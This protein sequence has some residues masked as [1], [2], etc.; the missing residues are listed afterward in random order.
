[1][2]RR[3]KTFRHAP[4]FS[5]QQPELR[6]ILAASHFALGLAHAGQEQWDEALSEYQ[7]AL[8]RFQALGQPWDIAN[9]QYEMGLVYSARQGAGDSDEAR[10]SFEQALV[11]FQ[12]LQAEPGMA[13]VRA[14]LESLN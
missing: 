5:P 7:D 10:Q 3:H 2:E 1:M 11:T 9:T 12:N 14:A 8:T 6:P 4:R 13:K